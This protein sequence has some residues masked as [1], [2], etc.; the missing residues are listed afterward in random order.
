M[1]FV[2]TFDIYFFDKHLFIKCVKEEKF[3]YH[4]FKD[5]VPHNW[6]QFVDDAE[7][8]SCLEGENQT[9]VNIFSKC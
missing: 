9:V 6:F 5:F 7:A 2:F 4:S 8:V 1:Q 3:G